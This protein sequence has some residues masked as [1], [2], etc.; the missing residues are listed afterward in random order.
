[1]M[2]LLQ[3]GFLL[4]MAHAV[5]DFP[6]QGPVM[7]KAKNR[8]TVPDNVLPGQTPTP[9]WFYWLT[10]HAL[11]NAAG[12]YVVTQ[13]IGLAVAEFVCHWCIDFLK[14]ENVTNP[15]QDQALHLLCKVAEAAVKA[16]LL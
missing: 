9:T 2:A 10:A 6:L 5:T 3:T 13:R 7:A 15:H 1:M 8:H 12:V 11:I 16:G 14:C 4:L